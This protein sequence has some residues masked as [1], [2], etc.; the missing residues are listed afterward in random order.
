MLTFNSLQAPIKLVRRS[1]LRTLEG[2]LMA[3]NLHK[4]LI[5]LEVD[6][7]RTPR[8]ELR[9]KHNCPALTFCTT[10]SGLSRDYTPRSENIYAYA[11][12]RGL[13]RESVFGEVGHFLFCRFSPKLAASDTLIDY[14]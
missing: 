6:M 4:A 7:T 1:D 3:E 11:S 2:S 8:C 5:K 12:E 14:T 10:S 9:A 13:Y